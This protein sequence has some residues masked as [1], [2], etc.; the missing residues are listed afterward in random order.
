MSEVQKR[1]VGVGRRVRVGRVR[2]V[3]E[4]GSRTTCLGGVACVYLG[5]EGRMAVVMS[6]EAKMSK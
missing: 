3:C 6:V 4:G 1:C 5:L 2:C